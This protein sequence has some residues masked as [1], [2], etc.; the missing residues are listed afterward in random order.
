MEDQANPEPVKKTT[1]RKYTKKQENIKVSDDSSNL[2]ESAS[3]K[4]SSSENKYLNKLLESYEEQITMLK[5][6]LK[7]KNDLIFDLVQ[8]RKTFDNQL[9]HSNDLHSNDSLRNQSHCK[10]D[11]ALLTDGLKQTST[12]TQVDFSDLNLLP[13]VEEQTSLLENNWIKDDINIPIQS[14]E[15]KWTVVQQKGRSITNLQYGQ[16][17]IQNNRFCGLICSEP[18]EEP[19]NT[20]DMSSSYLNASVSSSRDPPRRPAVVPP[21]F[22]ERGHNFSKKVQPGNS[23]YASRVRFGKSVLLV[24]DSMIGRIR[25]RDF[26]NAMKEAGLTA[27]MRKKFFPGGKTKELAHYITPTLDEQNPDVLILNV[28]TNNLQDRDFNATNLASDIIT[29]CQNAR[30]KGVNTIFVSSIVARKDLS[31][32]RR[33]DEVNRIL[34]NE[35]KENGFFFIS[36]E[37]ILHD[38]LCNDGIHLLDEGL[39][40]L[41]NNFIFYLNN[42]LR[43]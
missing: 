33:L 8:S 24:G 13:D 14:D 18:V 21:Q 34:E 19:E 43:Q 25:V 17:L 32:Q 38:H 16:S 20:V 9:H 7:I 2:V 27:T 42:F 31:L 28:G 30:E 12:Q 22:P 37:N 10:S 11:N 5:G 40:M 1:K 3:A 23:S 41:A 4:D 6:E 35:C 39:K 15:S 29:I 36:N 26:N